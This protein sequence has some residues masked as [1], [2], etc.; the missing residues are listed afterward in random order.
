MTYNVKTIKLHTAVPNRRPIIYFMAGLQ[1]SGKSGFAKS[2]LTDTTFRINKDDLRNMMQNGRDVW[3]HPIESVARAGSRAIGTQA[4]EQGFNIIIDDLGFN[5]KDENF[6]LELAKEKNYNMAIKFIDTP[7]DVCKH[8]CNE[9]GNKVTG[10]VVQK[11]YDDYKSRI[12]ELRN[13]DSE[14]KNYYGI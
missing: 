1:G 2:Q 3:S 12:R 7:L 8:R 11:T 13:A 9:R 10:K 14:Y 6:W 5:K 4:L